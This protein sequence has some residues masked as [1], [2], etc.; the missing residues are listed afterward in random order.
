MT[1]DEMQKK[2]RYWSRLYRAADVAVGKHLAQYIHKQTG[3]TL[4][5]ERCPNIAFK[6]DGKTYAARVKIEIEEVYEVKNG[7]GTENSY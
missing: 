6:Y 3:E 7:E 2:R 5:G 4:S 1:W